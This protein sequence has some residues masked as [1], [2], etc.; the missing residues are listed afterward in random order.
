[1][2]IRKFANER[3]RIGRASLEVLIEYTNRK[4]TISLQLKDNKIIIKAPRTV[5]RKNLDEVI[6]TLIK[7]FGEGSDFFKILVQVFQETLGDDSHDHLKYFYAIVPPLCISWVEASLQAKDAMH[8]LTRGASVREM[9]FADDGF[10][11]GIAYCLAVLKQTNKYESFNWQESVK[12]HQK[13]E[14]KK[15]K[16]MKEAMRVKEDAIKKKKKRQSSIIGSL[17]SLG[18]SKQDD[19]DDDEVDAAE[20]DLE[21]FN[22]LQ[23]S[24]KKL[25]NQKRE[26]EQLAF[27][28]NGAEIFFRRSDLR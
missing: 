6:C 22:T 23:V 13:K 9:Y 12:M 25:E 26:S 28:I 1:M 4:R 3:V 21:A 10:A 15:V 11:M 27:S 2:R 7:N 17:M 20:A 5:S 8:K 18:K 19:D 16:D 14:Y 24:E